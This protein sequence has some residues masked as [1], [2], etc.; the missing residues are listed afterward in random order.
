MRTQLKPTIVLSG[1]GKD[2]H[3]FG[4]VLSVMLGGDQTGGTLTVML[5][6]T[7]PGGG[8]PPHVHSR[9]DELFLVAEGRVSFFVEGNWT[10]VEAGGAVFLPK[11]TVHCYRNVGTTPSRQWILTNPSGFENFF[12]RCAQEFRSPGGPDMNRIVEI[13][14][15]HGI[16]YVTGGQG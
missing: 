13:S 12:A 9:E 11:G 6:V 8:P 7:P 3:A 1:M 10:E 15:E 5:D 16:E 14:R 4:D 2:L